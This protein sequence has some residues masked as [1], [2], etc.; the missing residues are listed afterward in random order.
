MRALRYLYLLTLIIWLGG[1]V[2]LGALAAPA[3]FEVLE[4]S[5]PDMGRVLAGDVF[6]E[7][8]RRFHFV[9]YASGVILL[10]CLGAMATRRPR[11][12]ALG[13]RAGIVGAMLVISLY[14]GVWVSGAIEELQQEIGVPISTLQDDDPRRSR[15][16]MLHGLSEILMG[17]NIAGGLVL[18]Y[19]EGTAFERS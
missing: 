17:I 3:V 9:A 2:T 16:D 12:R 5:D 14:S 10:G 7:I 15:F 11:P 1:M 13:V 18:V 8:L 6:G 4:A 19:W